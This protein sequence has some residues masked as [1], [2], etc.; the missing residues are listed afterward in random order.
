LE[1]QIGKGF[2][3]IVFEGKW[4]SSTVA[5]KQLNSPTMSE[6]D[7]SQFLIEAEFMK[8]MQP[9]KN[10]VTFIGICET[11]FCII[12]DYV[13]R[14]SLSE[15]LYSKLPMDFQL[16]L[17]ILQ[18]IAAGMLHLSLEKIVHRDL[19]ARNILITESFDAKVADFGL[20]KLSSDGSGNKL[21]ER[22]DVGPIKWMAPESLSRNIFST[23][24]DVYSFGI[25][26]VEVFTRKKPYPEIT[27]EQFVERIKEKTLP[28]A[29]TYIP[30]HVPSS[31]IEL[32][33]NCTIT[34]PEKRPSFQD[35]C[36][37]LKSI[38][39]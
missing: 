9:H 30:R 5:V 26:I 8:N 3:G 6:Q 12:T 14:G 37:S 16:Q 23:K 38:E 11:P 39:T 24:S 4:R 29:V 33:V 25:L 20:S 34:E 28:L 17:H 21:Y 2:F 18:D 10:V 13:E 19:A 15:M 31:V 35:I 22:S 7:I 27:I 1:N 32:L 36:T